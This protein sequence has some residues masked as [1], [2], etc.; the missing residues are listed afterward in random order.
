MPIPMVAIWIGVFW[1]EP[2]EGSLPLHQ[3]RSGHRLM[4]GATALAVVGTLVVAL[5]AGS[6]WEMSE[7]AATG[8]IEAERYI[9]AVRG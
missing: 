9:E 5:T 1:G 2:T 7:R 4:V 8:L 6:L 3:N